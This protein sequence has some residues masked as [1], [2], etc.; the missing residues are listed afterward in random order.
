PTKSTLPLAWLFPVEGSAV[1]DATVATSL[2]C[3]TS[4]AVIVTRTVVR[5]P[6]GSVPRSHVTVKDVTGPELG[7]AQVPDG[8]A[9]TDTS[10]KGLA[11]VRTSVN[12]TPVASDGPRLSMWMSQ[13]PLVPAFAGVSG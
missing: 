8:V 2:T 10:E 9:V 12:V 5:P 13:N 11:D 1:A 7:G 4:L 6:A 3:A